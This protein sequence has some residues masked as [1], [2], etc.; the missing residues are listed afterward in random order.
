MRENGY[1]GPIVMVSADDT[2]ENRNMSY[3]RFA[4]GR[5]GVLYHCRNEL[6]YGRQIGKHVAPAIEVGPSR[7]VAPISFHGLPPATFW[8]E[9][10]VIRTKLADD[11]AYAGVFVHCYEHLLDYLGD[12]NQSA[13]K[14]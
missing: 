2:E 5:N 6:A 9:L 10:N 13:P 12:K 8:Q 1:T 11:A 4:A 7:D 14:E 3:R